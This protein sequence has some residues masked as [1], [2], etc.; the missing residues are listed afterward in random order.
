MKLRYWMLVY[1][2]HLS[3]N[4]DM[5]P[6]P[7]TAPPSEVGQGTK[8]VSFTVEVPDDLFGTVEVPAALDMNSEKRNG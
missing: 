7:M 6:M 1:P 2:F 4:P 8:L 3:G 5:K